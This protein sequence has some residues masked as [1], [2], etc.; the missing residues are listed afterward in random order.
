MKLRQKQK[1]ILL[2]LCL[3]FAFAIG[4]LPI[5]TFFAGK[6]AHASSF[7][8]VSITNGDFNLSPTATYLETDPTGWQKQTSALGTFGA[9]NTADK[10]WSKDNTNTTYRLSANP[11]TMA[12]DPK[13]TKILMLNARTSTEDTKISA[14]RS[15]TSNGYKSNKIS[16]NANSYYKLTILVKTEFFP[17]KDASSVSSGAF[18]SI[19]ISGFTTDAANNQA[20]WE[21]IQTNNVWK[22]YNFYVQTGI[23]SEEISVELWLGT[24]TGIKSPYAVFYD[25]ISLLKLSQTTYQNEKVVN[26]NNKVI[27]LERYFLPSVNN[28]DFE[29]GNILSK[30]A[31]EYD[32]TPSVSGFPAN[33]VHRIINTNYASEMTGYNH[34]G[35]DGLNG[36][37][38][39]W[40]A[41]KDAITTEFGYVSSKIEINKFGYYKISVNAKVDENTT[42]KVVLKEGDDVVDFLKDSGVREENITYTPVTK[43][44]TINSNPSTLITNNYG[45][46]SFLI[47]ADSLYNTSVKLQLLLVS[48][49]NQ[50][51]L[52][53]GSVVFDNVIVEK[54]SSSEYETGTGSSND[55]KVDLSTI[56]GTPSISNGTF[57]DVEVLKSDSTFPLAP[58]NWTSSVKDKSENVYGIVNTQTQHYDANK[59][60]YGNMTNPKN[61]SGISTDIESNNVLMLYNKVASYQSVKSDAISISQNTYYNLTLKFKTTHDNVNF[62]VQLL[63]QDGIKVFEKTNLHSS[64]AWLDFNITI[65]VSTSS[66][67]SL[68]LVLGLGNASNPSQGHVFIDNVSLITLSS[69]TSAQFK[70]EETAS[71]SMSLRNT[72]DL[73]QYLMNSPI[74]NADNSYEITAFTGKY[75]SGNANS[76]AGVING[77]SNDRNVQNSPDNTSSKFIY[78]IENYA[79]AN[80]SLTS[81]D[82]FNLETDKIYKFSIFVKTNFENP[83]EDYKQEYG[84]IVSL[85][86]LNDNIKNINTS[87]EWEEII[88]VVRTT[89]QTSVNLQLALSTQTETSG[90]AYFDNFTFST[91]TTEEYQAF[92]AEDEKGEN[93]NLL[94]IGSTDIEE[95][96]EDEEDNTGSNFSWLIIPSLLT[97]VA[98]I[99]AIVGTILRRVNFKKFAKK[100]QTEYDRKDTLYRDMIRK[101]AEAQRDAEL[102]AL[103][104]SLNE[105]TTTLAE[106]EEQNKE[107][108]A[109]QRKSRGK[110]LDKSVEKEFKAYA[111]KRTKLEKQKEQLVAVIENKNTS[112]Y[113]LA[114][115][116]KIKDQKLKEALKAAQAD[117]AK[118]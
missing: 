40:L 52:T 59:A 72:L 92:V 105:I 83:G 30:T 113:L 100:K 53:S 42:A 102:K 11:Q 69:Y 77:M 106:I 58:K 31:G 8:T 57:N 16:L 81:I 14:D 46:Y 95:E 47:K 1:F 2:T 34:L 18:G 29:T 39:L 62:N 74:K 114:L 76:N 88:I 63:S 66:I 96:P 112:E 61:P 15:Q 78:Y 20:K 60:S 87:N 93:K 116:K 49:D 21:L 27:E 12:A 32:W 35:G 19:Y 41:A 73:S 117:K 38:A 65:Q 115:Q 85:V 51:G 89:G 70:A 13:D 9:I 118:K 79:T 6:Q 109:M 3:A 23:E 44:I 4:S 43:E 64:N 80:Y 111:A 54:L 55:A 33:T 5:N 99:L 75:E 37:Y 94:I 50:S 98:L 22:Q 10:N 28:A 26:S 17:K 24:K 67:S 82:S 91:L 108:L 90:V 86:G 101:E 36:N 104:A 7:E 107:R 56:T 25:N 103:N 97:G 68:S 110:A 45:T 84:A 71:E 48:S